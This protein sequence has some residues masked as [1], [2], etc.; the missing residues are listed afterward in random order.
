MRTEPLQKNLIFLLPYNRL[1]SKL[2]CQFT[3]DSMDQGI[4]RDI[5]GRSGTH[6]VKTVRPVRKIKNCDII[7][8]DICQRSR[9]PE[10]HCG[11]EQCL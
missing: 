8:G 9:V 11:N 2:Q 5:S 6:Q 10:V 1:C 7:K 3:V 4:F